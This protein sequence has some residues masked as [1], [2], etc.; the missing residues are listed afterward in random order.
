MPLLIRN[1][2][3]LL[4]DKPGK[5]LPETVMEPREEVIPFGRTPPP[6]RSCLADEG[7]GVN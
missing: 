6:F 4:Q 1:P 2:R 3:V 5:K 7:L